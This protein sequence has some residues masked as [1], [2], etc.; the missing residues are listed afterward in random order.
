MTR[1]KIPFQQL[2]DALL[3]ENTPFNPRYLY[4]LSDLSRAD[5]DRIAEVWPRVAVWRRQALME[6]L[7]V[8]GEKDYILSFE[9]LCRMALADD[10]PKV[11]NTSIRM[12]WDYEEP[13]LIHLFLGMLENDTDD[14][15]RATAAQALGRFVYMGEVEELPE[16]TFHELEDRLLAV[17]NSDQAGLIRRKALEALG[18]SSHPAITPLI[19]KAF[20]SGE[21]DWV[22]SALFAMGRSA[23]E[24]WE[25]PVLSMLNNPHPIIRSEAARAAG[26]LELTESAPTLLEMLTDDN[27]DVRAAAIWSLSQIG[28]QG[29]RQVLEDMLENAEFEEEIEYLDAA[30]D[31]LTFNEEMQLFALFDL[32]DQVEV[33]ETADEE[34]LLLDLLDEDD[35][36]ELED[37][38]E[39][40]D[41]DEDEAGFD[42]DEEEDDFD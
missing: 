5:L 13:D 28:G 17:V 1:S 9:A 8:L 20:A 35:Y 42:L 4:R 38:F 21:R 26:E 3:D 32:P 14:A 25:G 18:Y 33:V 24:K 27:D 15:V 37:E 22:A 39:F 7:E 2:L 6:D 23:N 41:E 40:F 34:S 11:R 16:D 29:V 30:L 31:N 36:V 19:E 12:L 10:D